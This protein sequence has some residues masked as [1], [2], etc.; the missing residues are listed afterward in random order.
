MYYNIGVPI[1]NECYYNY[2]YNKI[3]HRRPLNYPAET[4]TLPL[5]AAIRTA[6]AAYGLYLHHI[7]IMQRK[8]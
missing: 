8:I 3:E 1:Y 6:A 7:I 4:W 2:L 5:R